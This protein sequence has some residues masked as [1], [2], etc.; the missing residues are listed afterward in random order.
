MVK[1]DVLETRVI[2]CGKSRLIPAKEF[3]GEAHAEIEAA[4]KQQLA[5]YRASCD[6]VLSQTPL[7]ILSIRPAV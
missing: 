1:A 7:T 4:R 3:P 6:S 5:Y 2:S